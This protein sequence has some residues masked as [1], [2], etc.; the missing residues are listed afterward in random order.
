MRIHVALLGLASLAL[1]A[2]GGGGGGGGDGEFIISNG[3]IDGIELP[4]GG[5]LA[6]FPQDVQD[7]ITE[8]QDRNENTPAAT[9]IPTMG[10]ANYSGTFGISVENGDEILAVIAGDLSLTADWD[11]PF[12]DLV[13]GNVT[14]LT[15][16]DG[17]GAALNPT[18]NLA[19]DAPIAGDALD[20]GTITGTVTIEGEDYDVDGRFDGSFA[21]DGATSML[22]QS[23]GGVTNPDNSEDTFFGL[24]FAD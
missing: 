16:E 12:G 1:T 9:N 8:F 5:D 24:W 22:G 18:G 7:L 2:C 10:T 14:N 23:E 6:A 20:L 3:V 21:G 13:T 17:T 4:T 15:G 19:I 11:N